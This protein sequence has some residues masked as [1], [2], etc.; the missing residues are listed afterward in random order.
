MIILEKKKMNIGLERF[1]EKKIKRTLNFFQMIGS[2]FLPK[3][4][5]CWPASGLL[6]V[7]ETSLR[8]RLV[9]FDN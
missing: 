6:L 7:T 5:K 2:L 3:F 4:K 9:N 8:D 1:F